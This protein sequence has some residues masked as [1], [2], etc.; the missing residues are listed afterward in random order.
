MSYGL[1]CARNSE[2]VDR[3]S[4]DKHEAVPASHDTSHLV[5]CAR[6]E[7]RSDAHQGY[8]A[9]IILAVTGKNWFASI[10][11]DEEVFAVGGPVNVAL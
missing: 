11:E 4:A 9:Y 10:T 7:Q 5:A 3:A 8:K 2:E 6:H 1:A